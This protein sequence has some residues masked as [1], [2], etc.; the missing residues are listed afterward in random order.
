LR[1]LVNDV[2]DSTKLSAY[3]GD[4]VSSNELN[5]TSLSPLLTSLLAWPRGH[6]WWK[7]CY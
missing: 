7:K 4:N 6:K 1:R 2:P 5:Y 3:H